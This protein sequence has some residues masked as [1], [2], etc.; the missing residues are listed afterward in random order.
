MLRLCVFSKIFPGFHPVSGH[1]G[2]D[3]GVHL[4]LSSPGYTGEPP[5]VLG[6]GAGYR[7]ARHCCLSGLCEKERQNIKV[8][9]QFA[10]Q[11]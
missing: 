2:G 6:E 3:D 10:G 9:E 8:Q 11:F 1:S 7:L 5:A 4:K